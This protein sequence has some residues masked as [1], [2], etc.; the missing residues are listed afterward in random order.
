MIEPVGALTK[1][2]K[3]HGAAVLIDGA[4]APGVLDI[5]VHDLAAD[6]Y[7]GNCHKWMFSPKG[8]A[9]LWVSPQFSL[10]QSERTPHI[11]CP[12]PAVISSSGAYDFVGRFAYTGT[13][14]YTSFAAFPAAWEFIEKECGGMTRMREYCTTLLKKGCDM[15]VEQWR[16][17]YL[18]RNLCM[19]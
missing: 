2:C 12:Q 13:R 3:D 17:Y 14:D 15:L 1:L 10:S 9:F 4:H 7:L 6:F 11:Q 19:C 8:A 16:T 18:V 5:D